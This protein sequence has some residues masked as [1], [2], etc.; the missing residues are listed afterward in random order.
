[1]SELATGKNGYDASLETFR[2][3]AIPGTTALITDLAG[4]LTILLIP[5]DIIREMALNASYGMLAIIVTN[6]ILMPIWLTYMDVKDVDSFVKKQDAREA[7]LLP[8]FRAMTVVTRPVPAALVIIGSAACFGF[9][10]WKSGGMIYGDA[11][12]GVPELRPD[13]RYNNDSN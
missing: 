10:L 13:S 1:V 8:L 12:A 5:I 7:I 6:K 11:Q 2:R 3:L 9:A 4:F